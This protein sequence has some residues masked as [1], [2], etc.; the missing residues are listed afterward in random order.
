MQKEHRGGNGLWSKER[1]V[2]D[3]F[4]KDGWAEGTGRR[5]VGDEVNEKGWAASD[6][7]V[8]MGDKFVPL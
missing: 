1:G 5:A 8:Q 2:G 4:C 3:G 7:A 6:R